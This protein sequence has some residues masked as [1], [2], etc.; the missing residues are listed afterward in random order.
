MTPFAGGEG[1]WFADGTVFFTTKI[2]NHVRAYDPA[3]ERMEVVYDGSGL[4]TGVDNI[5]VESGSGDLYVAEDGGDMQIVVIADDGTLSPVVQVVGE[6]LP[7]EAVP[8]EVTGPVFSPDGTRLYFSSQRGGDPQTGITYEVSG[9]FRGVGATEPAPTTSIAAANG[10]GSAAPAGDDD[11][12][13]SPVVPIA[14]GVGVAAA[15]G[16]IA[17]RRRGA[18]TDT[19][20]TEDADALIDLVGVGHAERDQLTQYRNELSRGRRRRW[21]GRGARAT[22]G[23]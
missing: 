20:A 9:P 2:D 18:A 16:V 19:T 14:I 5:T 13:S 15:A 4:L 3:A 6:P 8:S 22:G 11:E 12:G 1:A 10:D 7:A 21:G 23:R 17:L